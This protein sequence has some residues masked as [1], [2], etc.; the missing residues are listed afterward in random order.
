MLA[1]RAGVFAAG[2]LMLFLGL[3]QMEHRFLD[4]ESRRPYGGG[5]HGQAASNRTGC[6][7]IV[8]VP[9]ERS[10]GE[11]RVALVPASIK[12]LLNAGMRVVVQRGAGTAAGFGDADY[13]ARG[14]D[15][16]DD[17]GE[18]V[19]AA[20]ILAC[21]GP[22]TAAGHAGDASGFDPADLRSGQILVALLDPFGNPAAVQRLAAAGVTSFAL[23][24]LP[25]I[26]RAQA[27]DALSSMATVAGY[28][29]VLLAAVQQGK[30]FP[31]LITA[32]GTLLPVKVLVVGAGVA[33]LQAI[34]TA[35]RLGA[36]VVAYD[37]RPA[38]REQVESLGA[39]FLELELESATA[40]DAGGYAVEMDEAFYARQRQLM[41][42][43]VA[44]ND[45][46]ITTAAI[47]GKRAPTLI[48]DEMVGGM[49]PG[50]VI[51]D[52]AVE[53]GGN[54][55]LSRAGETV[56]ANGVTIMGPVGLP[57]SVPAHASQMYSKNVTEFLLN[58]VRNGEPA[59]DADDE[60]IRQTMLTHGGE[61][62][63][64]TVRD[65][66]GVRQGADDS[67]PGSDR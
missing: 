4:P 35:R 32:A 14:A 41:T 6:G 18:L 37:I 29:A 34:A 60:I 64:A 55:E 50:S 3:R 8:G 26:S 22:P 5:V 53:T 47:P 40:E 67:S 63:S 13:E 65:A 33:G 24:L 20:E 1:N 19:A 43:A 62:V 36:V 59:F 21:V 51:V 12:P 15:L 38:V 45:V 31:M 52:L 16:A 56:E 57:A 9:A 48:T 27:M 46:V 7:V 58:L 30:M 39:G 49:A 66:L 17:A 23:E 44:D 25:R 54:C 28:K 2:T 10:A 61:V 11:R 42:T